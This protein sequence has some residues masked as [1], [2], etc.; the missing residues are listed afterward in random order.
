MKKT[1]FHGNKSAKGFALIQSV[2]VIFIV[3][4]LLSSLAE[5]YKGKITLLKKQKE[6]LIKTYEIKTEEVN[7]ID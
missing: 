4:V 3:S 6:V 7:E 1:L 5:G 2:L